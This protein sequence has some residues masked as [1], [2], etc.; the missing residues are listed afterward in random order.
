[1]LLMHRLQRVLTEVLSGLGF[2]AVDEDV[3]F[4][5]RAVDHQRD[6]V[7][8]AV[9]EAIVVLG[10][11]RACIGRRNR[12]TRL[13]LSDIARREIDERLTLTVC[14]IADIDYA[15]EN[16]L[17]SFAVNQTT[18]VA[19]PLLGEAARAPGEIDV[20]DAVVAAGLVLVVESNLAVGDEWLRL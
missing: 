11:F 3:K 12:P 6:H 5:G 17:A 1:M 4:L 19:L 2:F 9:I 7:G 10:G 14:L 20:G 13:I 18:S 16:W 8:L 15:R